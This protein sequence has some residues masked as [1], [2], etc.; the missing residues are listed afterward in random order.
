MLTRLL[1]SCVECGNLLRVLSVCLPCL[2]TN[3]PV[4]IYDTLYTTYMI[5]NL[6]PYFELG[7]DTDA[8]KALRVVDGAIFV[9]KSAPLGTAVKVGTPHYTTWNNV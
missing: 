1:I 8:S 6:P 7:V 3:V 4:A 5:Q 2:L 9:A